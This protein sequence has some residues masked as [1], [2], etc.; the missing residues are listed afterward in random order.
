MGISG[1]VAFAGFDAL[2]T[3]VAI[4]DREGAIVYTNRAWRE[5]E[6]SDER[7]AEL[8]PTTVN[9]LD[10]CESSDDEDGGAVATGI[11]AVLRGTKDV[12]AFEY[13]CPSPTEEQWFTMRASR[14]EH[15]GEPYV[16]VMH[17]DITERKLAERKLERTATHLRN[18]TE[19][20]SHDLRN[21]LAVATIYTELLADDYGSSD[22]LEKVRLALDRMNGMLG[23]ALA[24]A[25]YG[26]VAEEDM[27]WVD[28]AEVADRAWGTVATE[29]GRLAIAGT[30][31]F[32]AEP[33]FLQHVFENLF[34]NAIE[35]AAPRTGSEASGDTGS[36]GQ[37]VVGQSSL[38]H[39]EAL[40]T[41]EVGPLAD[42]FYV[43]DD[44]VGI[45]PDDRERVFDAGYTTTADGT[46]F[47]LGIVARIVEAH[48]W[49]I[50]AMEAESGGA[51]FEVTGIDSDR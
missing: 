47:G 34:R 37:R 5:L 32:R 45:S 21:P 4:L 26:A 6:G 27:Q 28:L 19:L 1:E 24:L 3:Q 49:Q 2:P 7:D 35:H 17:L 50:R 40:V 22:A 9:Y 14:F 48:G 18:L 12:F 41:V 39:A 44:G 46:G 10:V 15:D 23:D 13:P 51:R 8:E 30:V 16:L 31:S 20:L 42:G 33:K 43:A 29:Q 11:R 25:R 38:E 36:R